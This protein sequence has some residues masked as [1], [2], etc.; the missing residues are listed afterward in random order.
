[1]TATNCQQLIVIPNIFVPTNQPFTLCYRQIMW[2]RQIIRS[3]KQFQFHKTCPTFQ[4]IQHRH[5][6]AEIWTSPFLQCFFFSYSVKV[7]ASRGQ[8]SQNY[9]REHPADETRCRGVSRSLFWLQRLP[10]DLPGQGLPLYG[11][12]RQQQRKDGERCW[13]HLQERYPVGSAK[14]LL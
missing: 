14:W 4:N 6:S 1:M 3:M 2:A 7:V 5:K 8:P 12:G 11:C 10:M 13:C 9:P